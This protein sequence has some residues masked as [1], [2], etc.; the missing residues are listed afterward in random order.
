MMKMRALIAAGLVV[1]TFGAAVAKLPP[2]PPLTDAQKE[3]KK[4]VIV[5]HAVFDFTLAIWSWCALPVL[6]RAGLCA[7]VLDI[8][9]IGV[10][11]SAATTTSTRAW[12]GLVA[13]IPSTPM[14]VT[15]WCAAAPMPSIPSCS[16]TRP[17]PVLKALAR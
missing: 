4:T 2:A 9:D 8:N 10:F 16:I 15:V 3:E 6:A 1:A 11:S 12:L 13:P 14:V 5:A 17:S 7:G